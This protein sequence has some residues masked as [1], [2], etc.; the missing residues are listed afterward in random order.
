MK[1]NNFACKGLLPGGVELHEGGSL[2]DK[3]G[4]CGSLFKFLSFNILPETFP[5]R[6][7]L[8]MDNYIPFNNN[9]KKKTYNLCEKWKIS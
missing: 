5:N 7:W 2:I 9:M 1:K 6:I 8:L 3:F 4:M